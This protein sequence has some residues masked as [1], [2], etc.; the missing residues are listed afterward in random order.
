L[1]VRLPDRKRTGD[2]AAKSFRKAQAA[3]REAGADNVALILQ[4]CL[5]EGD[6]IAEAGLRAQPKVKDTPEADK[7]D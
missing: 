6:V 2:I 1:R 7:G 5:A 4:G 3:I